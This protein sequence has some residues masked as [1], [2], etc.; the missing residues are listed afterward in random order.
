MDFQAKLKPFGSFKDSADGWLKCPKCG[1]RGPEG[2][3]SVLYHAEWNGYLEYDC[4]RCKYEWNTKTA[5]AND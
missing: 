3:F 2:S 1:H 4:P 5:D